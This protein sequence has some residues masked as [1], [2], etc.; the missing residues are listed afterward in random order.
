MHGTSNPKLFLS[1]TR[2]VSHGCVRVEKIAALA[3]LVLGDDEIGL[4]S[5]EGDDEVNP[6]VDIAI[7]AG[8]TEHLALAEPLPVYMLYWTAIGG[9]DGV[10]GFRP[11][12]YDRDPPLLAKLNESAP[13]TDNTQA[14]VSSMR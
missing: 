1:D 4:Y 14:S 12:R 2:E 10:A 9:P 3:S 11:D 5:G 8:D 13:R 6:D 7:A